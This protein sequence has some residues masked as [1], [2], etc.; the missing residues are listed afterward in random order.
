MVS[1]LRNVD[2][3]HFTNVARSRSND[4]V[5]SVAAML[6]RV[7]HVLCD[8]GNLDGGIPTLLGVTGLVVPSNVARAHWERALALKTEKHPDGKM[9]KERLSTEGVQRKRMTTAYAVSIHVVQPGATSL[10]NPNPKVRNERR[11]L[12][13]YVGRL[14]RIKTPSLFVQMAAKM[15]LEEHEAGKKESNNKNNKNNNKSRPYLFWMVGSGPQRAFLEEL[16]D[17]LLR[18]SLPSWRN[19]LSFQGSLSRD[20]VQFMLS[21]EVD[22]VVHTTTTNETFGLSNVEAMAAGVPVVSTCVGGVADYLRFGSMHGSC[23]EG[24]DDLVQELAELVSTLSEDDELWKEKSRAG[25]EYVMEREL[26][27]EGMVH[28]FARLYRMLGR[29]VKSTNNKLI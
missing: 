19:V 20:R 15:L 27:R 12:V 24:K 25:R 11:T 10:S 8:P 26:T 1:S 2:I 21:K 18:A 7:P 13:C 14:D 3:V 9:K 22:V 28:R 4:R 6:A 5:I 16:A 17:G 29:Q 23:V